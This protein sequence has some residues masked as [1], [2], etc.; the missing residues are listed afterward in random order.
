[1]HNL[2][3]A[4]GQAARNAQGVVGR[5]K[6]ALVASKEKEKVAEAI[7]RQQEK[8]ERKRGQESRN[9]GIEKVLPREHRRYYLEEDKTRRQ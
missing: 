4:N 9:R 7:R 3:G 8:K 5:V 6:T 2:H 1:M